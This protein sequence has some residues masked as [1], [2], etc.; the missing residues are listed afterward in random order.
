[1][2]NV[3]IGGGIQ[4]HTRNMKKINSASLPPCHKSLEKHIQRA[5]YVAKIWRRCNESDPTDGLEP[6]NNGWKMIGQT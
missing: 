4:A 5:Q 3:S 2:Y 1:M 6:V